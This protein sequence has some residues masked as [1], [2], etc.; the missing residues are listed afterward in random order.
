MKLTINRL[1]DYFAHALII[2]HDAY[3]V[4]VPAGSR[5]RGVR[6]SP[7]SALIFAL[8]GKARYCV[9]GTDYD[10][11]PG[12]VLHAG[13][14]LTLDKE[15]L[16]SGDWEYVLVHYSAEKGGERC[17]ANQNFIL[18]YGAN[19]RLKELLLQFCTAWSTPGDI[20]ALRTKQ[21]FYTVME[22]LLNSIRQNE[23]KSGRDVIEQAL[24]NVSRYYM[25]E[26]TVQH[27]AEL[28]GLDKRRFAYLFD[29]Y[30]GMSPLDYII[31]FRMKKAKDL[32]MSQTCSITQVAA[33]VGYGDP[34]YF[35]RLF[36]KR[37]GLSPS[38][39]QSLGQKNP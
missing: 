27:L 39:L 28:S 2:I 21:L 6:T 1:A 23:N 7:T 8:R 18:H 38:E 14:D 17:L 26:L 22:E 24:E 32:I 3:R 31:A 12:A 37:M 36:K 30:V 33:C 15:V 16:P 19:P 20:Q 4:V 10:L 9:D 11:E 25:E 13:P 34:F 29:K 5:L 35:S